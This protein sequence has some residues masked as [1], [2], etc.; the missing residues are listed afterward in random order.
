MHLDLWVIEA[1]EN[2]EFDKIGPSV[3][4]KGHLKHYAGMLGLPAT[5]IL[6]DVSTSQTADAAQRSNLRMRTQE[7]VGIE[8]P[9]GT[10]AAAAI[11]AVVISGVV[12]LRPWRP[13]AAAAPSAAAEQ[14]VAPT[15]LPAATDDVA[16]PDAAEDAPNSA[17]LVADEAQPSSKPAVVARSLPITRVVVAPTVAAGALAA[18]APA[19]GMPA[20]VTPAAVTPVSNSTAA[21]VPAAPLPGS[22]RA[23]LR[24]SFSADSHVEVRDASGNSVFAGSGRANSVKTISGDAPLRV[25]LGFASGVQL[26]VNDHVVAI[27]PQF[28]SGDVARFEA[29]A[30]GVLRRDTHSASSSAA[31]PR[32]PRPRG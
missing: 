3:Y 5:D 29:G 2:D 25:Y 11:A 31:A 6:T 28:F 1:L 15:V 23:R 32:A 24:L 30:D 7:P 17:P 18:V 13:R 22:G 12:W 16:E 14:A 10:I 8:L 21:V 20:A 26:S 9:W 27:A 4:A 19:A